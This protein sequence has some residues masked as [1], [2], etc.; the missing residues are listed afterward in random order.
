MIALV[1]D[2]LL[3]PSHSG[4]WQRARERACGYRSDRRTQRAAPHQ[5]P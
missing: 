5:R 4:R 1:A 3:S 2:A